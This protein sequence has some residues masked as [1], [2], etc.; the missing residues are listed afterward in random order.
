MR[1]GWPLDPLS[2]VS[3]RLELLSGGCPLGCATGFVIK[4]NDKAYLITN[5]HVLSGKH[6]ETNATLSPT[7]DIPDEVRIN[8][9]SKQITSWVT[10]IE[11]LFDSQGHPRWLE[12]SD[13]IKLDVV[14]L[15]LR[16]LDDEIQ[17]HPIDLTLAD[18]DIM[19]MVAMPVS[20]IGFPMGIVASF[21]FPIWKTGHIASDYGWNYRDKP[22]F[23]IDATT[24][25][26][27]S[28]APVVMRVFGGYFTNSRQY[29]IAQQS[30]GVCTRFLGIYSGRVHSES[31]IGIVWYP[32]VIR[33]ILEQRIA[34]T[35]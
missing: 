22:A 27:M 33:D 18:T 21:S 17:L 1:I 30:G 4:W 25:Q 7:G 29:V 31:E 26:G 23:L 15:P 35:P 24:R 16:E 6:R 28:G 9:H 34:A 2:L 14:A 8:H 32:H 13:N 3:L 10:S 20:I 12:L 11:P 19:P 5:W